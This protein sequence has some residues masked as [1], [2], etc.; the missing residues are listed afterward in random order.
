MSQHQQDQWE[1]NK[2]EVIKCQIFD[3]IN[4]KQ[5]AINVIVYGK[6]P[7]KSWPDK[8]SKV[9]QLAISYCANKLGC[10]TSKIMFIV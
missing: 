2:I 8:F 5:I 10:K 6:V 1:I 9:Y 7:W 4:A 3:A